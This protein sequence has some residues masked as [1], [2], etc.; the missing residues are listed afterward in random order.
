MNLDRPGM[1]VL[2]D[3]A[4]LVLLSSRANEAAEINEKNYPCRCPQV[5]LLGTKATYTFPAFEVW[6]I[7]ALVASKSHEAICFF[8]LSGKV[9]QLGGPMTCFSGTR[10]MC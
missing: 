8:V 1:T 2:M 7:S 3:G 10:V 5:L 6:L 4:C 9:E